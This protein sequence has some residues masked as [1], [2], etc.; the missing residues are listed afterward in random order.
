MDILAFC[1]KRNIPT[2]GFK[3]RQIV[4]WHR[5]HTDQSK[6]RLS[7]EL[8]VEFPEKY[9]KAVAKAAKNCLVANLGQGI[10]AAS[11]ER[12]IHFHAKV[13]IDI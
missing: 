13:P 1:R 9:E 12:T 7:I 3:I 11:F 2:E 6:V 4:D 8:P 10:S 5:K